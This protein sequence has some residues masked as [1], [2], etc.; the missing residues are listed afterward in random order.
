MGVLE[1]IGYPN[2]RIIAIQEG[3]LIDKSLT[4]TSHYSLIPRIAIYLTTHHS[5][6]QFLLREFPLTEQRI[7]LSEYDLLQRIH[8]A[9]F[10]SLNTASPSLWAPR[11]RRRAPTVLWCIS[12]RNQNMY[13]EGSR[14]FV[15]FCSYLYACKLKVA[16]CKAQVLKG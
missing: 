16:R 9:L 11:N 10:S 7:F 4:R 6:H 5:L 13:T 1:L 15:G 14:I 3:N 2:H 8:I 12:S